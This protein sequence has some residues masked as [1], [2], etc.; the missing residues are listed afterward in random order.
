MNKEQSI[1][2]KDVN[3]I[4][5]NGYKALTDINLDISKGDFVSIIGSSGAGKTTLMKTLNKVNPITSG[6][7]SVF[8]NDVGKLSEKDLRNFRKNIGLIYQSYNLIETTTVLK[9]VLVAVT[10]TLPWYRKIIVFYT[11]REKLHAL[12]C[13]DKVGLLNKAYVRADNLSGGQM[14]RVALARTIAQCPSLILADEPV[15][16]LDPI[17]SKI[18]MDSFYKLNKKDGYTVVANLHHVDLALKYSDKI[19]GVKDGKVAYYGP[20]QKIDEKILKNIYG[21]ELSI[22][23]EE[24]QRAIKENK[25]L[26]ANEK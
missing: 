25:E 9:N 26:R 19:I 3:L 18:I 2:F 5:P 11:K 8:N 6:S 21:N 24:I 16:A 22:K 23:K 10:P 17:M 4:Y 14:Q 20:S 13:L 15:A 7:L 1:I 12:S